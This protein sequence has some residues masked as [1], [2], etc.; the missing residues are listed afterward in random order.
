MITYWTNTE[1]FGLKKTLEDITS[2]SNSITWTLYVNSLEDSLLFPTVKE[3]F[4]LNGDVITSN[5]A[6]EIGY[7]GVEKVKTSEPTV[8][9]LE[10]LWTEE[11]SDRVTLVYAPNNK[12]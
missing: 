6:E 11:L 8:K 9:W 12:I 3:T 10:D 7:I 1:P 2:L 5:T 4:F